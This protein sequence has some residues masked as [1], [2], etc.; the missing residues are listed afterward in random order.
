M[1]TSIFTNLPYGDGE[2]ITSLPSLRTR[3]AVKGSDRL[4]IPLR[5]NSKNGG[6]YP[7]LFLFLLHLPSDLKEKEAKRLKKERDV[8][9]Q[10]YY[11]SLRGWRDEHIHSSYSLLRV[12][13]KATSTLATSI[14]AILP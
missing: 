3:K 4:P 10:S 1:A 14:L 9:L 8:Y 7:S 5:K 11:S 6:S 2:I 13:D 12:G